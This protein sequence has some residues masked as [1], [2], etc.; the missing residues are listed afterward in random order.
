MYA[1]DLML[2]AP[3]L[4]ALQQ[5]VNICIDEASH[6]NVQFIPRKCSVIRFKPVYF[7]ECQPIPG[8]IQEFMIGGRVVRVGAVV[9]GWSP[10]R[11]PGAEPL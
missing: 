3:S 8:R 9:L 11:A 2:A 1:D 6:I 5:M 4:R 7:K 10:Q